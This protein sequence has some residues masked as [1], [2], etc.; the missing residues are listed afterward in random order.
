MWW[1]NRREI[2]SLKD[3]LDALEWGSGPRPA[4]LE[5]LR[6]EFA[7]QGKAQ[8][9]RL[10][11]LRLEIKKAAKWGTVAAVGTATL[12]GWQVWQQRVLIQQQ[13]E[14]ISQQASDTEIVRRT[15]LLTLVYETPDCDL[16]A[17]K[18]EADAEF[19]KKYGDLEDLVFGLSTAA[20]Y[21]SFG[22]LRDYLRHSGWSRMY[23]QVREDF[24]IG[25]CPPKAPLRLRQEAVVA[26][27]RIDGR[28][29]DLSESHLNGADLMGAHLNN[30]DLSFAGL[31]DANLSFAGLRG[32]NLKDANLRDTNLSD[33]NLRRANLRGTDLRRANLFGAHLNYADLSDANLRNADLGAADLNEAFLFGSDLRR[34]E[35]LTQEQLNVTCGDSR[36][37]I[38][39]R[40]ERPKHWLDRPFQILSDLLQREGCP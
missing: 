36:T 13:G 17:E 16:E 30:A 5:D 35:F 27:A 9:R 10:Y 26:L 7:L 31:R 22:A 24:R 18:A 29:L 39:K 25:H 4:D 38:S 15:Q 37:R 23:Q 20:D 21:F 32:A 40:L 33:A 2:E 6:K 19:R 28:A 14:Q 11:R 8:G 3:R 34:A 1:R 12:L